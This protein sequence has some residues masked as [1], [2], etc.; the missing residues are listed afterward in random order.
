MFKFINIK[1]EF[2]KIFR[3]PIVAMMF[4]APILINIIFRLLLVFL[5]PFIQRY[6]SFDMSQYQH[7][8]LG[9]TMMLSAMLLSMVMGFT[10]IDDRD[11]KIV[12]LISVTPMG[13][14]GYLI[15]RLSLVF[16]FVFVY[17]IYTYAFMGIY[18]LSVF[19]L[20]YLSALLCVYSAIMGMLLFSIATD[21]VNGLTYAKGLNVVF[22]FGFVD[23]LNIRWLNILGGFFP[24]Y[25]IMQIIADPKNISA[26]FM[27]AVVTIGWFFIILKKAKI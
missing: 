15:M 13:R 1:S 10:M 18:I 8:V 17:S 19:A 2:K 9:F 16:L 25:W 23:L 21:K 26:L 3:D 11:N 6:V 4:L 24:P 22:L 7:Y 5:V 12:E 20:L 14:S 27:G